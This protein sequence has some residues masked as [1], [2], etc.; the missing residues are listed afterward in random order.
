[1]DAALSALYRT[2]ICTC[3]GISGWEA[4][5]PPV[6]WC[7]LLRPLRYPQVV[8]QAAISFPQRDAD[9]PRTA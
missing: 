3:V 5:H 8:S 1:M 7:K 2:A 9:A 6:S 4:L